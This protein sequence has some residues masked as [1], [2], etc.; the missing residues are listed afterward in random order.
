[1]RKEML[2]QIRG[3]HIDIELRLRRAR[4][5]LGTCT[6]VL[7]TRSY[8]VDVSG[9]KYRRNRRQLRTSQERPTTAPVAGMDPGVG[10]G[11]NS[12]EPEN[13]SIANEPN[14]EHVPSLDGESFA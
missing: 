11:Q 3:S 7:D 6:R 1:M 14:H 2:T 5:T 9:R 10:P 13:H 8:K 12:R 4:E